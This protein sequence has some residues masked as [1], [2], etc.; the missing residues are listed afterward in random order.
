MI[1]VTFQLFASLIIY[2]FPPFNSCCSVLAARFCKY[3]KFNKPANPS[4]FYLFKSVMAYFFFW[5]QLLKENS[6]QAKCGLRFYLRMHG[7]YL[8]LLSSS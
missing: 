5:D 7:K 4:M 6:A 1:D 2:P 3:N 8:T